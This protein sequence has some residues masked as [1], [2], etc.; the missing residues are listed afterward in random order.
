MR[1]HTKAVLLAVLLASNP[2]A[3][4]LSSSLDISQYAHTAWRSGE[5]F[6]VKGVIAGIAQ[7]PDGYLWI[8]AEFGTLL[9]FDG[10]RTVPLNLPIHGP[11]APCSRAAT[12]HSGLARNVASRAGRPAR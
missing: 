1:A 5:G 4:A 11:V 8:A 7:T 9:R 10:I 3:F 2:R 6:P 12:E